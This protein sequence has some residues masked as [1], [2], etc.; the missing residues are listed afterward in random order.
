MDGT[1]IEPVTPA[2]GRQPDTWENVRRGGRHIKLLHERPVGIALAPSL[3]AESSL[4]AILFSFGASVQD[5]DARPALKSGPTLEALKYVKALYEE[6]MSEEVLGWDASSNNRAMLGDEISLTLNSNVI[7][8]AGENKQLPLT[9]D[10]WLTQPPQGPVQRLTPANVIA[11]YVIWKF[12]QQIDAAKQ[13][14][15]DYIGQSRGRFLA[16]GF[17]NYP[18]FPNTVPDLA[19]LLANDASAHP[20][21]K[22][23]VMAEQADWTV[24]YGY[25]G[26]DNAAISEV[27]NVGLIPTMFASAATGKMTPEEALT[28]ADQEV[29]KIYD[30]WHALGKI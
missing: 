21:D 25:P 16:G 5:N 18:C 13:F 3:D 28:Q 26:Y 24:N 22:Y 1:E 6:A 20:P 15:V 4:M 12:A 14:L 9:P 19:Q 29:R 23:Q 8:R 2:V 17:F 10:I 30:K 7:T 27:Y 11:C